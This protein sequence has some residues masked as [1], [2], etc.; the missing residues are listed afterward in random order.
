MKEGQPHFWKF[1]RKR[2]DIPFCQTHLY[3]SSETIKIIM[4]KDESQNIFVY[5]FEHPFTFLFHLFL[6]QNPVIK[7]KNQKRSFLSFFTLKWKNQRSSRHVWT[8]NWRETST[9]TTGSFIR[10][11]YLENKKN[12]WFEKED[13]KF[14]KALWDTTKTKRKVQKRNKNIASWDWCLSH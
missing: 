2:F 14:W 5:I 10:N 9:K 4:K 7:E 3:S 6:E 13:S 8:L 12:W 1:K 11:R